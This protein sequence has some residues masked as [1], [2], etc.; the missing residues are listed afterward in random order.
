VQ[1]FATIARGLRSV[2]TVSHLEAGFWEQFETFQSVS[3]DLARFNDLEKVVERALELALALTGSS[4]AFNTLADNRGARKQVYSRAESPSQTLSNDEIEGMPEQASDGARLRSAALSTLCSQPLQAGGRTLGMIGV[5]NRTGYTTVQRRAFALFANPLASA[6][7]IARLHQR[8]QELVD[9]L[10]NLRAD[11][12]R[13]EAQ[14]L[15]NEERARSAERL[16][17]AHELA[18]EALLAVSVH[19]RFSSEPAGGAG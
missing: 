6:I 10:V 14:R 12:D 2:E 5:V 1:S 15:L 17:K 8:R 13:S 4:A 9:A 3:A 11:L 19:A 16:E 7:E 18:V